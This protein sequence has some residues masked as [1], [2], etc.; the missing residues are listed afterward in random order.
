MKK[1]KLDFIS[2]FLE[3]AAIETFIFEEKVCAGQRNL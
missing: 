2:I 3:F 1:A